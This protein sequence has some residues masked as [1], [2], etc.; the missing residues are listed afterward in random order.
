MANDILVLADHVGGQLSDAT[1]ELVGKAKELAGA[2]GGQAVVAVLGAPDPEWGQRVVAVVVPSD[3]RTAPSLEPLRELV[4]EELPA[5]AAP[6]Q[7]VTVDRLPV[8]ALGKVRRD[9]LAA[10]VERAF[11]E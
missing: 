4:K 10:L 11:R 7:L 5:Y 6:H 2:T 1:L 9:A 3:G 8:T